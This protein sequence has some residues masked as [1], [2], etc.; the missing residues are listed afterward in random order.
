MSLWGFHLGPYRGLPRP[1]FK[2]DRQT[3]TLQSH[4]ALLSPGSLASL[5]CERMDGLFP[6]PPVVR[7]AHT[8][9]LVHLRGLCLHLS[10]HTLPS[11]A[12]PNA[13]CAVCHRLW[14]PKSRC[15]VDIV[16]CFCPGIFTK[17]SGGYY[18]VESLTETEW[19]R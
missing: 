2:S 1:Q 8:G 14:I 11:L 6:Q 3:L 19:P 9:C 7:L 15:A 12:P 10:L 5:L 13:T 16:E 18:L 4:R 17:P